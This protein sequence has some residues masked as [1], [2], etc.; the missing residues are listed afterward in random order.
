MPS[1]ASLYVCRPSATDGSAA[2][3]GHENVF[4]LV[5][6]PAD[7]SIGAGGVDGGGDPRVEELADT[8]I[9]QIA[10]WADVPDLAER[11][12]VRRSY[13]PQDFASDLNAWRGTSLGPAHILKQSA[14][15]RG[16]H[17]S[18]HVENLLYAGSSTIPGIGIPMCLISA[19]LV[20]KRL[21]GDTS[22]GPLA[23][24]AVG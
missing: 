17:R 21:R 13:G 4:V 10:A 11:I 12:V 16:S 7:V 23:E 3:E 9:A 1:P 24:P 14:F 2:P 18:A 15:F 5:P 20:V 6:I 22:T 19:E 8:V